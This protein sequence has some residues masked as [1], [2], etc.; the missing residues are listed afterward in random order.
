MCMYMYPL[1]INMVSKNRSLEKVT[2]SF[3]SCFLI[4]W[5]ASSAGEWPVSRM[6]VIQLTNHK[7]DLWIHGMLKNGRSRFQS[8]W[9][10]A[11]FIQTLMRIDGHQLSRFIVQHLLVCCSEIEL[12]EHLAPSQ[13]ITWLVYLWRGVHCHFTIH[14]NPNATISLG[15]RDDWHSEWSTLLRTSNLHLYHCTQSRL[16]DLWT[17]ARNKALQEPAYSLDRKQFWCIQ[18]SYYS[19]GPLPNACLP[20]YSLYTDLCPTAVIGSMV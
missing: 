17:L 10:P 16:E 3:L 1:G 9:Q 7:Q 14:T 19:A 6:T 20:S 13:E 18:P 11:A 12:T 15:Y 5:N 4:R 8:I 2:L